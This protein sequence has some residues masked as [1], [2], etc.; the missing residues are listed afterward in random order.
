MGAVERVI[1]EN[2]ELLELWAGAD[3]LAWAAAVQDLLS[4]LRWQFAKAHRRVGKA[5]V[6]ACSLTAKAAP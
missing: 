1:A 6:A 3:D 5:A 2:S 4:R